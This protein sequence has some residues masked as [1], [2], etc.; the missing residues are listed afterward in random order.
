MNGVIGI[1]AVIAL[2]AI[3]MG[4]YSLGYNEGL[5]QAAK[6]TAECVNIA[7]NYLQEEKDA[8]AQRLE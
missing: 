2:L 7:F 8:A 6:M 5:R 1:L 4:V 3:Y